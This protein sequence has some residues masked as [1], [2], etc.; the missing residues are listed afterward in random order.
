MDSSRVLIH[1]DVDCFY[2]QVEE[3]RD[4]ALI[5]KPL[6]VTQKNLVVTCNYEAR[7]YGV[8]KLMTRSEVGLRPTEPNG[9][10]MS[11]VH[12]LSGCVQGSPYG[13]ERCVVMKRPTPRST[14]L[15]GVGLDSISCDVGTDWADTT[16]LW[17]GGTVGP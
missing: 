7:S 16:A 9:H 2:C 11:G 14:L 12:R 5:G 13:V 10:L 17:G 6:G 4:R 15:C 1:V 3:T 8:S